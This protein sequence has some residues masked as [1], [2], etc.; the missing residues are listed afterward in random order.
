[1]DITIE[2]S[3]RCC[4]MS[5]S[6]HTVVGIFE[7]YDGRPISELIKE[8]SGVH[9]ESSDLLSKKVCSDCES[10]TL[11]FHAFRQLCIDSDDTVRYNL[12]LSDDS[13]FNDPIISDE[14]L[15]KVDDESH[16]EEYF[17]EDDSVEHTNYKQ[18]NIEYEEQFAKDDGNL[19]DHI[20]ANIETSDEDSDFDKNIVVIEKVDMEKKNSVVIERVDTRLSTA[21]SLVFEPGEDLTEKMRLA[22]FAKEQQKKHKCPHCDKYFMFP[23]KGMCIIHSTSRLIS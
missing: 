4:L 8:I 22:H 6:A 2:N 21:N 13:D 15:K 16:V 3:C 5:L 11:E 10:K 18:E 1:M 7:E 14:T 19:A 12:L 17:I 23:S 9:I 20:F